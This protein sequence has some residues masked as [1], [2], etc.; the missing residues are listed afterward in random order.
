MNAKIVDSILRRSTRAASILVAYFLLVPGLARSDSSTNPPGSTRIDFGMPEHLGRQVAPT[1]SA[2]WSAPDLRGYTSL[3]KSAEPSPIEPQKRYNI[4]ELIDIAERVNPETRVAW[5][6]ARKAAIAVGLVESEYFPML[7]LSALGGYQSEAFPAPKDVAPNGFFRANLNQILPTLNLRWLLLDFGRRGN[8]WDAAKERLLAANLGFNRKHQEIIF[9]V[10][11]AFLG[12]TSLRGKIGVA[13]SAVDS[14][15]AVRESAEAQLRNGLATLPEVSLARQQEAQAAFDLEDVLATERDGQ[16]ALAESIGIPPTTPIEVTDF[17]ALPPPAALED[18]ADK[19]IDQALERRPDL[20]AKVAALRGKEAEV[21]RAR[22][23]YFPTLSLASN[24][25]T[26]AGRVKITGGNQPT[27][28]FSATEP[29]YGAGLFLQWNLFEG[30]ATQRK[31]ELAE[32]ER[33]AAQDEV[34]ASRDKAVRDVWK[35]YTDVRLA[36]RRLDVAAALLDASQKSY[37]ST[38][39]SYRRGLET[40]I[41]LLAARRELSRARFVELDTKVQ[42]L[43]ASAALAFT[44]GAPQ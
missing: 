20:I 15:R 8:T 25:N 5:E 3:L 30:G 11:R 32:A 26:L 42:L 18:S 27:G 34:T 40:L 37:E 10:Q 31:V 21:R 17:S 43:N 23:D 7:T 16:V 24:V 14:A 41:N 38:L 4:V 22:A 12:L 9:N 13:Q 29:S 35:A 44:T 1:P 6:A 39:E 36:V 19:V 33:R 28:W 2:P